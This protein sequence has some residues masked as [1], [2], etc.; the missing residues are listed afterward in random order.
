MNLSLKERTKMCVSH[1]C[2]HIVQLYF[3]DQM[4]TQDTKYNLER[5]C[6]KR[7]SGFEKHVLWWRG[8]LRFVSKF[9]QLK[10]V[11]ML[12]ESSL[13]GNLSSLIPCWCS[14][15]G[16]VCEMIWPRSLASPGEEVPLYMNQG[17]GMVWASKTT[18]KMQLL[19]GY[20]KYIEHTFFH[21]VVV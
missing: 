4:C 7:L 13:G 8:G 15:K 20:Q 2:W 17:W 11:G 5:R 12:Q 14:S 19:Q 18:F 9:F 1:I 10:D 21:Y 16:R 3:L 6:Q